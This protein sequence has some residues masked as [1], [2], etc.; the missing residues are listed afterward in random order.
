MWTWERWQWRSTPY[1]PKLQHYW[2]LTI[3]FFS[4]ISRTL[5]GGGILTPLQRCSRF[6]LQ[7]Q[8]TGQDKIERKRILDGNEGII[9]LCSFLFYLFNIGWSA[10]QKWGRRSALYP[11]FLTHPQLLS[12]G[13]YLYLSVFFLFQTTNCTLQIF[14]YPG[15]HFR[16][17][18][19]VDIWP[20]EIEKVGRQ[21]KLGVPE[22]FEWRGAT[23][24]WQKE[25]RKSKSWGSL[26]NSMKVVSGLVRSEF[27]LDTIR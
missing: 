23:G 15:D 16:P 9:V 1:S 3:K 4:V 7:P 27:Q 25:S 21:T 24:S 11:T 10:R 5:V 19:A 12:N 14:K 2:Y 6:I 22:Q 20:L 17:R 8:P 26:N 18:S 13:S